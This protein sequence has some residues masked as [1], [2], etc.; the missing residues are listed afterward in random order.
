M[1]LYLAVFHRAE[2]FQ[3]FIHR[4]LIGCEIGL[5]DMRREGGGGYLLLI[6]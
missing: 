1:C 6:A 4:K 2:L 3:C 5:D